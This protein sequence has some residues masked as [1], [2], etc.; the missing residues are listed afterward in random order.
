MPAPAIHLC[1]IEWAAREIVVPVAGPI[2]ETIGLRSAVEA[3]SVFN[4]YPAWR[5][6]SYNRL[7]RDRR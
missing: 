2:A 4:G 7:Q 1:G 6:E 3:M 5:E